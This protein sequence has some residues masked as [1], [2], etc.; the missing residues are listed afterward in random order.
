MSDIVIGIILF[1]GGLLMFFKPDIVWLIQHSW[2]TKGGE[3]TDSYLIYT[4][5][6]GVFFII[7]GIALIITELTK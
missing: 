7:I 3:P 5:I 1:L 6:V 4:K 2:D